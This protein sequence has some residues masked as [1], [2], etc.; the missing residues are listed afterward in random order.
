MKEE[1]EKK[2]Y[3]TKPSSPW[4]RTDTAWST[5]VRS[6][7][8]AW[9]RFEWNQKVFSTYVLNSYQNTRMTKG[10]RKTVKELFI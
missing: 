3:A 8:A 9:K 2:M 6:V 1:E 5:V 7:N 10:M 4:A